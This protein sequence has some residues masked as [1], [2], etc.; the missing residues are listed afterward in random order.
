M[1]KLFLKRYTQISKEIN[2]MDSHL[3]CNV[4]DIWAIV[5]TSIKKLSLN[6]G[7]E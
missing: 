6:L 7:I 5:T 3:H 1:L 2:V 4:L